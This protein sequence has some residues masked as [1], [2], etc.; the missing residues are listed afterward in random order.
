MNL[1]SMHAASKDCCCAKKV[2]LILHFNEWHADSKECCCAKVMIHLHLFLRIWK[3]KEWREGGKEDAQTEFKRDTE[4]WCSFS[5]CHWFCDILNVGKDRK[6]WLTP[7]DWWNMKFLVSLC[8][9][10][11]CMCWWWYKGTWRRSACPC[12]LH[13]FSLQSICK[14]GALCS[15]WFSFLVPCWQDAADFINMNGLCTK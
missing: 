10:S 9:H 7:W 3:S 6:A 2:M 11:K 5:E 12:C 13:E 15:A 14:N 1:H 8:R 4:M